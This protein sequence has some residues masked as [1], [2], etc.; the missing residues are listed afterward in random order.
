MNN[1]FL[2]F[3]CYVFI[4]FS[5]MT[6]LV[7]EWDYNSTTYKEDVYLTLIEIEILIFV[8]TRMN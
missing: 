8:Y 5:I 1:H 2:S 4:I 3:P 7:K 6:I